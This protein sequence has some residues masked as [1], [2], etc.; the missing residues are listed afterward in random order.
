MD[1]K[2]ILLFLSLILVKHL[3]SSFEGQTLI[4]QRPQG[5]S[6]GKML[7]RKGIQG[8]QQ[9][10]QIEMK[11]HSTR[12]DRRVYLSIILDH[13]EG[14]SIYSDNSCD[15]RGGTQVIYSN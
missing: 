8:I 10:V 12:T 13:M 15:L 11:T 14:D 5:Y 1:T 3:S 7:W 4:E 2:K 6:E 9:E